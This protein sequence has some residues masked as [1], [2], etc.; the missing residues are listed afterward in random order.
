MVCSL[1]ERGT[2]GPVPD[3]APV[4]PL[5]LLVSG[6]GAC[7]IATKVSFPL[8]AKDEGG[9]EKMAMPKNAASHAGALGV[10]IFPIMCSLNRQQ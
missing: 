8:W 10:Y 1:Q 5:V 6:A 7:A 2:V 3:W 4:W 9:T